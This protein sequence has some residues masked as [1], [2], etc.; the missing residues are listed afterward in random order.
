MTGHEQQQ[1]INPLVAQIISANA[2]QLAAVTNAQI[3]HLT[4][5]LETTQATLDAVRAGILR[6]LEGPYAP[7]EL[8][9]RWALYPND[10]AVD[11][12]RPAKESRP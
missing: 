6:L 9:I 3:D 4:T 2:A 1:P 11:L 8:A 5:Q 12:H 7:S 10:A